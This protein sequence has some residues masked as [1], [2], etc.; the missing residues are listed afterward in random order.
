LK[1]MLQNLKEKF[2]HFIFRMLFNLD[3]YSIT[4]EKLI[5]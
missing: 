3:F 2:F 1:K 5:L 4:T